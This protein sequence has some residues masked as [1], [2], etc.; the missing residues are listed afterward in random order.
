MSLIGTVLA[1]AAALG[2]SGQDPVV[3]WTQDEVSSALERAGFSNIEDSTMDLAFPSLNAFVDD[4][5]TVSVV[6]Q[7]CGTRVPAAND[8]CAVAAIS[9]VLG[10]VETPAAMAVVNAF[11]A[12][13]VSTP[14][15]NLSLL[16]APAAD[17]NG[18]ARS[19]LLFSHYLAS[20]GGVALGALDAQLQAMRIVAGE[21]R[22]F[23]AE[24]QR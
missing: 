2:L 3:G 16:D 24:T 1:L 4:A 6:R 20:D 14:G 21:A 12:S 5:I 22:T 10:P 18:E 11:E 19:I 8:R 9:F 13:A 17:G 23:L 7:V 15:T